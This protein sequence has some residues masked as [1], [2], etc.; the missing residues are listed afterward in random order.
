MKL[1]AFPI[2]YMNIRVKHIQSHLV[3][4]D[5]ELQDLKKQKEIKLE[6]HSQVWCMKCKAEGHHRYYYLVFQYYIVVGVSNLLK[7]ESST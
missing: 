7:P 5:M 1:E 2:Q 6:T 4:L 3:S